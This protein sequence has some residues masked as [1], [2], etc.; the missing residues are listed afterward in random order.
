[1]SYDMLRSPPH[2][3][4]ALSRSKCRK[5]V[6]HRPWSLN[7]RVRHTKQNAACKENKAYIV[8]AGLGCEQSVRLTF[9]DSFVSFF[10]LCLVLILIY[11]CHVNWKGCLW[12]VVCLCVDVLFFCVYGLLNQITYGMVPGFLLF[13]IGWC[14]C[15]AA[16]CVGVGQIGQGDV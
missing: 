16:V 8:Y 15:C 9:V 11:L 7:L 4:P 3:K 1:M 5:D 12:L 2:P 6:E 14:W 10:V 13:L